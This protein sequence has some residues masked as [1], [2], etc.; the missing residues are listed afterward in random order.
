MR[1]HFTAF[2]GDGVH[3]RLDTCQCSGIQDNVGRIGQLDH[4]PRCFPPTIADATGSARS[5]HAIASCG[6][7][8]FC[9]LATPDSSSGHL[10]V[11]AQQITVEALVRRSP[12]TRRERLTCAQAPAQEGPTLK[13]AVRKRG[14]VMLAAIRKDIQLYLTLQKA[15]WQPDDSASVQTV[16]ARCNNDVVKLQTPMYRTLPDATRSAVARMLS[17]TGTASSG[18]CI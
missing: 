18:Q 4:M 16:A 7:V 12:I 15:V 14:Q 1:R 9:S 2:A 5:T 11:V 6:R 13:R 8:T 3:D 10:H 17:S